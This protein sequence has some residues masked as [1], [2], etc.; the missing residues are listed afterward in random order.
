M[1]LTPVLT[2]ILLSSAFSTV[3]LA[4]NEPVPPLPKLLSQRQQM[5]VREA[6][7]KKRLDTLVLPMMRKHGLSMWIVVNEEFN[8]DPATA[9]IAPPMS[10]VG[11]RDFFI[12][13]DAG[14]KL[15]K[16]AVVRYSDERVKNHY[17]MI[18]V[19]RDNLAETLRAT[20]AKYSPKNIGLN[21]TG[22]RGQQN[23]I[24]YA[25]Y[26]MLAETLGPENEKKFVSTANF[27]SDFFDTRLPEEFEHY[28][29]AVLVTDI[30]TR[31]A[32]SDEVIRP[33]KTT[34]GDVKWWFLE[35]LS[36]LGLSTWFHPDL[37]IQRPSVTATTDQQFL[38]IADESTVLQRGDLIHI[39]C[40][41]NY[42]GLSTDWQ[43]HAYILKA[44]EKDAP[45]GL[46]AALRNTNALQ[47]A[48][49]AVARPGMTGSEVYA[50][51]MDEMKRQKIEAMIYS[52]PIGTHGHGL[53]PSIDFRPA[54]TGAEERFRLGSYT[55][56][57]LN[58][59]TPL[60]EWKGQK[61]TIMAEDDAVMNANGFKFVRPRQTSIYVI[62]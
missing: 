32:F 30:L 15:D 23:G 39:D 1:R 44:G 55:S 51:A 50:A 8:D 2:I 3:G 28:Q 36:R 60:P 53:G 37:R 11:S 24:S 56:I 42:M 40:G 33:G 43:K 16:I 20:V 47:D 54:I 49:F 34:V 58:T 5:D 41:L 61:V 4:Q 19:S 21:M 38:S 48:I 7:L 14:T 46:K 31:R 22:T 62:R 26:R 10:I 35:Q 6:W 12:F 27:L 13:A 9:Y 45:A 18:S 59:S 29:N 25:S 52:H 57:E 17:E